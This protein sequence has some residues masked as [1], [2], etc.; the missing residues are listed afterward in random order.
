[1]QIE[2]ICLDEQYRIQGGEVTALLSERP[3]DWEW[4]AWKRP[5]L[6]VVPGGGY[7]MVSKREADPVAFRFLAKG[8]Q[9][10]ILNYLC[11]P[12]AHYP[13]QLL[14]LAC[15][16]DYIRKN[17]EKYKVNPKEIFAV[18]FSA[19]GHL[20]GNLSTD[21]R[22]AIEA[23]GEE[24]D[25]KLTAGGLCYPVISA[26]HGHVWSFDNLTCNMDEEAK[27]TVLNKTYLDEVVNEHTSPAFLWATAE[28][29]VVPVMNSISYASA[30]A[31]QEINF[32]LH[33]YPQGVH[34][35]STCDAEINPY[36]A[37]LSKNEHWID[38]CISFFR[39]YIEEKF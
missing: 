28:D 4:D 2:K 25:C 23:Y 8:F 18:G 21:Y 22:Q 13:E 27:Q 38:D 11:A 33:I 16:V 32:E 12:T 36:G 39:L 10:F 31:K 20:V 9:V 15:T 24:L 35:L 37:H 7:G 17:C 26:K 6:I 1:M 5:A 29:Q 34:G 30:L 14:E 3:F 19:G